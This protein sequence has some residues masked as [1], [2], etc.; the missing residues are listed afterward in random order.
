VAIGLFVLGDLA[1]ARASLDGSYDG[2]SWIDVLWILA[3]VFLVAAGDV[4][5]RA[6]IERR[7]RRPMQW[8]QTSLTISPYLAVAMCSV[9]L[10]DSVRSYAFFPVL[11]L[12]SGLIVLTCLVAARQMAALH[13]SRVLLREMR[14]LATTDSLTGVYNRRHVLGEA[15][16]TLAESRAD[17]VPLTVL[18]IDIDHFKQFNDRHGHAVGD[19]ALQLVTRQC[20]A[21]LRVDQ[22]IVGRFGGDELLVVLPGATVTDAVLVAERI[23]IA[24]AR[25][26]LEPGLGELRVSLS[27]GVAEV[28]ADESI[29]RLMRRADIALYDAK[30]SGRG[31]TRAYNDVT[32]DVPPAPALDPTTAEP[33]EPVTG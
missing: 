9:L 10:L 30:R 6:P 22:D 17:G 33:A 32:E 19:L 7:E 24:V 1:F 20:M 31:R 27:I 11:G 3:L 18:M 29:T 4:H 21:L 14:R 15:D 2:R 13:D 12:A 5:H 25:Q 23:R 28:E 26:S 16:R 8:Q